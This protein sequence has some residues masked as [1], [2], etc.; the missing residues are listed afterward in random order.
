MAL[1]I[2]AIVV[3]A[4]CFLANARPNQTA[5]KGSAA[6]VVVAQKQRRVRG[7]CLRMVARASFGFAVSLTYCLRSWE[8]VV[9]IGG[10]YVEFYAL[11]ASDTTIVYRATTKANKTQ[12]DSAGFEHEKECASGGHLVWNFKGQSF[13]H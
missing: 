12:I 6:G 5:V 2:L 10:L 3:R 11:F 13:Q 9:C 4:P 8:F 1:L 7:S